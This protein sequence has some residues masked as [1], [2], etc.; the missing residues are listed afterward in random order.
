MSIAIAVI[1]GVIAITAIS[2]GFDYL[3]KRTKGA[4]GEL[5]K[6]MEDLENRIRLLESSAASKED[7]IRQLENKI[8]FMDRLLEDKTKQ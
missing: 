3:G 7:E 5:S 6:K 1:L 4:S 2:A 8:E